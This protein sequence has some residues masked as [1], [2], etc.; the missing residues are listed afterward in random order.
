MISKLIIAIVLALAPLPAYAQV[1]FELALAQQL[2]KQHAIGTDAGLASYVDALA[3]ALNAKDPSFGHLRKSGSQTQ[4]HGH[5]H[6]GVLHRGTGS[7]VDIV[8]AAG[9]PHASIAW[10]VHDPLYTAKDWMAPHNCGATEPTP[11]GPP[12]PTPPP[13][14]DLAPILAKL[15]GVESSLS[16]I[17]SELSRLGL[18][19]ASVGEGVTNVGIRV[20][21][22]LTSSDRIIRQ[23]LS[24]PTYSGG[25][26]FG[27]TLRPTVIPVKP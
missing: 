14:V 16:S 25:G 5:A 27:G 15:T 19:I 10:S 17:Q 21:S 12:Q 2:A 9:A 23:L 18:A 7:F 6:D 3:C 20:E 13:V 1:P 24:P 8:V 22:N 26:L 11:P 4:I